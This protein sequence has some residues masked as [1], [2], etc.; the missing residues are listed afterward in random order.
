VTPR[1]SIVLPCRNQAD[2]LGRILGDWLRVLGGTSFELIVVPNASSDSTREIADGFADRD[3]RV[4]VVDNPAGGWGAS[5][6]VGLEAA[7]GSVLV[8]TNS[9]RTDPAVV[10]ALLERHRPDRLVKLRRV[11]RQAPLRE[12]GSWLY[13]GEARLLFGV[14]SADVNGTPKIFA[15]DFYRRLRIKSTGDLF[16]LELLHHAQRAGLAV[17][18]VPIPGFR[19]H[20]GRSSTTLRSAWNMYVGAM[21]LR[22]AIA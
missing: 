7:R 21:K 5:V 15:A 20:G 1:T 4:R 17:D 11:A 22:W 3:G 18:E 2:H 8:Y 19:R 9:A 12:F 16:D 13:N 10:P 6:R 14:R